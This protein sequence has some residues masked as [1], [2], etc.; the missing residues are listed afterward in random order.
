VFAVTLSGQLEMNSMLDTIT[1]HLANPSPARPVDYGQMRE[2]VMTMKRNMPAEEVDRLPPHLEDSFS[3][4]WHSCSGYGVYSRVPIPKG[5]F[6]GHYTGR[7]VKKA[8]PESWYVWA[9][10]DDAHPGDSYIDGDYN[11][12][13]EAGYLSL[14]NT[15]ASSETANVLATLERDASGKTVRAYYTKRDIQ[16][17]EQLLVYYG[18]EYVELIKAGYAA[19]HLEVQHT[20]RWTESFLK[21]VAACGIEWMQDAET[22]ADALVLHPRIVE[23]GT[24]RI[25][26]SW[27]PTSMASVPASVF[28]LMGTRQL[29]KFA[30]GSA[31]TPQAVLDAVVRK[32]RAHIQECIGASNTFYAGPEELAVTEPNISTQAHELELDLTTLTS[33]VFSNPIETDPLISQQC[34]RLSISRSRLPFDV[35]PE[36]VKISPSPGLAAIELN[37]NITLE[38]IYALIKKRNQGYL[39]GVRVVRPAA[40]Y[41]ANDTEVAEENLEAAGTL[42]AESSGGDL[43]SL[44]ADTIGDLVRKQV[45]LASVSLPTSFTFKI[46]PGND[47]II[48]SLPR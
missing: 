45:S 47:V 26:T 24:H 37:L 10:F 17:N 23:N 2:Y 9:L 22:V 38:L 20:L 14:F 41:K 35:D 28:H 44:V 1:S 46:L 43:V 40:L 48:F 31:P 6:L 19:M 36:W 39:Q 21:R 8:A 5:A 34:M 29:D 33:L 18:E 7:V 30:S 4:R 12:V 16:P 25:G 42:V 27:L 15:S 11:N 32:I 3:A 13:P